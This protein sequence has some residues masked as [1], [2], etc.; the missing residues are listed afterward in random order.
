MNWQ[1]L[2]KMISNW[3]KTFWY[4]DLFKKKI[5]DSGVK[6]DVPPIVSQDIQLYGQ[7]EWPIC[8]ELSH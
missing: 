3:K 5:S 2:T 1:V 7:N 6:L 4:L 8:G